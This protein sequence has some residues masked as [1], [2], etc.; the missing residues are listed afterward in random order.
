MVKAGDLRSPDLFRVGS[1]PTP[2][3]SVHRIMAII[4]PFQG[5]EPGSI[6]GVRILEG[7]KSKDGR[8]VKA[9]DSRS[10]EKSR[11]FESHS[12]HFL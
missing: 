7:R 11:G 2:C 10:S 8:A 6:P 12:L 4:A 5:A 3:T 9:V 1:N